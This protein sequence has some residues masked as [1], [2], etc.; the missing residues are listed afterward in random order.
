[1]DKIS[2]LWQGAGYQD[3]LLQSYRSFHLTTQS[4]FIAT[5]VGLT[6]AVVSID[7]L[8]KCFLVYILLSLVSILGLYLLIKMKGLITAR[9]EDVDYYHSEIIEYEKELPENERVLIPFKYY[10]KYNRQQVAIDS[11]SQNLRLT[12]EVINSLIKKGKGHTRSFLDTNLFIG[13]YLI[14]FSFHIVSIITLI[15]K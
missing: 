6:I 2:T 13:Y 9:G 4:I 15:R 8:E 7:G 1:M 14:W 10:Q 5:G 11:S 3:N 12:D